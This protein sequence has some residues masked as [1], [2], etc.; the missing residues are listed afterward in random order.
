MFWRKYPENG[1]LCEN[2]FMFET[3]G[4]TLMLLVSRIKICILALENNASFIQLALG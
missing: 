2:A 1:F 4:R 3:Y